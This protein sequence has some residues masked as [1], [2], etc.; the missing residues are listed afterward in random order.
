MSNCKHGIEKERCEHCDWGGNH[1]ITVT[2]TMILAGQAMASELFNASIALQMDGLGGSN[3][4]ASNYSELALSYARGEV[5]SVEAIYIA[6][7][8]TVPPPA[9]Y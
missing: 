5:S 8:K 7:Q 2:P 6:M 1:E 3:A 4:D 9:S